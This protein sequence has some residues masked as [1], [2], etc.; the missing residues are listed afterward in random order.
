MTATSAPAQES[1]KDT[2]EAAPES[3]RRWLH[4]LLLDPENPGG[5]QR[6]LEG[7]I[8]ALIIANL[9]ALLFEHVPAVYEPKI[10]RAHV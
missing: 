5:H 10:G 2:G 1:V 4:R 8:S 3:I 6:A 7:W 9:V